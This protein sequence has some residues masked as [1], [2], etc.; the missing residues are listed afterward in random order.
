MCAGSWC[1][2]RNLAPC[3]SALCR[4]N[5][6][7]SDNTLHRL[8][9]IGFDFPFP[10]FRI[11]HAVVPSH[12]PFT[13]THI[14][15]LQRRIGTSSVSDDKWHLVWRTS[16]RNEIKQNDVPSFGTSHQRIHNLLTKAKPATGKRT[17][18]IGL[19]RNGKMTT[20]KEQSL[21]R[22]SKN[23]LTYTGHGCDE[24]GENGDYHY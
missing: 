24:T 8:D 2:C 6:L 7:I 3:I 11:L 10:F 19:I 15:Y 20:A 1:V 14:I 18:P 16:A 5:C 9:W 12:S 22:K 17:D 23:S 13:G 21:R 4:E